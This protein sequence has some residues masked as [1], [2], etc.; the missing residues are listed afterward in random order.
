MQVW[1]QDKPTPATRRLAHKAS[2]KGASP[3][4]RPSLE[5]WSSKSAGG[6]MRLLLPT[7]FR[8]LA[9]PSGSLEVALVEPCTSLGV[10][11]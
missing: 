3:P 4:G 5:H 1:P 10:A 2:Q 8:P 7:A 11:L 6:M 9:S